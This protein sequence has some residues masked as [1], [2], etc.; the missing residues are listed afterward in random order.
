MLTL[1]ECCQKLRVNTSHRIKNTI[2]R[3]DKVWKGRPTTTIGRLALSLNQN[4]QSLRDSATHR[5]PKEIKREKL[6]PINHYVIH[7]TTT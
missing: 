2:E 7:V 6:G 5:S 1:Q 3:S 4:C